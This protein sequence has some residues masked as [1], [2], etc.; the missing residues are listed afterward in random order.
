MESFYLHSSVFFLRY[1]IDVSKR[2][3]SMKI[4]IDFFYTV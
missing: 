4:L 3:D 1:E 2:F